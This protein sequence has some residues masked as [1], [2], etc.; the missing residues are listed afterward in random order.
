MWVCGLWPVLVFVIV[1]VCVCVCVFSPPL[2]AYLLDG[3]FF[4]A[5]ALASTLTK[6]GVRYMQQVD[7][8]QS[9]NVSRSPAVC[10]RV[11]RSSSVETVALCLQAF[12]GEAMLIVASI[13]H[14]GR[15][16]IPKK[17]NC[18]CACVHVQSPCCLLQPIT[19]DDVERL[20]VCLRV[21]SEQSPLLAQVFGEQSRSVFAKMLEV[22]EQEAKSDKKV[23]SGY[24]KTSPNHIFLLTL[25]KMEEDV[26]NIHADQV[27][28][29]LQLA[30]QQDEVGE[31]KYELSLLTAT[32]GGSAPTQKDSEKSNSQ[33]SKVLFFWCS[34]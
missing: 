8:V 2:R 28:N 16:G 33:L 9:K 1:C 24:N 19:E 18:V 22:R 29:F 12:C 13:L 3:K 11:C 10:I 34:V 25:Q 6:L 20:Y 17:V 31:N 7:Q 4:I 15:S 5:A 32:A 26:V 27:I 30:S 14:L 21:L 23:C